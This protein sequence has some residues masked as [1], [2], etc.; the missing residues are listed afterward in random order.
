MKPR[1]NRSFKKKKKSKLSSNLKN[2]LELLNELKQERLT[3]GYNG[4]LFNIHHTTKLSSTARKQ[5]VF[6]KQ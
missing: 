5:K 4:G 1:N 6:T 3:I 2:Q